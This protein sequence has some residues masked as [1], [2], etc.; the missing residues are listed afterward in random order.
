MEGHK[1]FKRPT[2]AIPPIRNTNK[3]WAR[4]DAEKACAFA[5]YFAKVFTP[6][7]EN[8]TED[9]LEV[10]AY[11]AASCQ[12]DLPLKYFS[13]KE[14]KNEINKISSRKTPGYDLIVSEI[15]KHLT[16]KALVLLTVTYNS[17]LRLC[18][19]PT[20][21][22]IIIILKPG[23]P[24]TEI[25]SYR[26]IS[27]LPIVSKLFERLLLNTIKASVPIS[28]LIPNHQFGFREGHATVQQCHRI[29]HC[30]ME[31]MEDKKMCTAVFLDIQQAFDK[32]WHKGL[33]YKLK[34]KNYRIE[35]PCFCNLT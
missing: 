8:N 7:P 26:P 27:L 18:Y 3:D 2:V 35:Y 23:K 6:L 22:Q 29:V 14:V 25:T 11:L 10:K 12:L 16:R 34:K 9:G 5:N 17:M 32:V 33:P 19:Y 30:I 13:P 28:T 4:S 20:F 21:A 31:S 1:K 15:L 24:E